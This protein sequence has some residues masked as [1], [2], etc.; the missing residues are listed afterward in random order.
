[1]FTDKPNPVDKPVLDGPHC[2]NFCRFFVTWNAVDYFYPS[3]SHVNYV[4]YMSVDDGE[5]RRA[6]DCINVHKIKCYN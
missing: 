3:R 2:D 6:N 5:Y 4:V 1:M